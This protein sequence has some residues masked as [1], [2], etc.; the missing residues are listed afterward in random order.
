MCALW[1]TCLQR[2]TKA[3]DF[4]ARSYHRDEFYTERDML[5]RLQ[6]CPNVIQLDFDMLTLD[7]D[8]G[9]LVMP[10]GYHGTLVD[11]VL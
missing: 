7:G 11:R 1:L 10:F 9:L 5:R 6:G 2:A 3:V 4:K 8:V